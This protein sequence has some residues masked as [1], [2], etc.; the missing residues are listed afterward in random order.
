[1]THTGHLSVPLYTPEKLGADWTHPSCPPQPHLPGECRCGHSQATLTSL[2]SSAAWALPSGSC[3]STL[4]APGQA[5][6]TSQGAGVLRRGGEASCSLSPSHPI[7]VWMICHGARPG[8][9]RMCNSIPSLHPRDASSVT[10]Y[11]QISPWGSNHPQLRTSI[12]CLKQGTCLKHQE[13]SR[14]VRTG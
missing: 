8:S 3:P 11:R 1:M 6:G 7:Q 5:A 4:H 14:A 10:R 2:P 12:L 13:S 9:Y